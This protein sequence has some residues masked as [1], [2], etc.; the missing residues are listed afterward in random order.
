MDIYNLVSFA[1][2]FVLAGVAWLFSSNKR[3]VNWRVLAGGIGLQVVFAVF[4]FVVPAG[5]TFFLFVNNVVV[6]VLD[7]AVA[8]STFLFG[9]LALP[10]GATNAAG[11]TSLGYFLIFQALPTIIFFAALVSAFYYLGIMPR[12]VKFFARIFSRS[13]R[14][15]GAESL[16]V[17]SEIFVG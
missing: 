11:E 6:K 2:I 12:L 3:V 17:S 4:I 7:S 16:C 10:P 5:R 15:S 1:G 14:V 9:R 8:G 13:M